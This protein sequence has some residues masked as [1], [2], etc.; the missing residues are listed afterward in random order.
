MTE[1]YIY[2]AVRSPRGK[3]R[4]DGAL[5]EITPI[6]LASQVLAAIRDRNGLSGAEIEDVAFGCVSP[7]GEQGA[8][9]TRTAILCRLSAHDIGH[10]GK[11]FL[12]FG[13]RGIQHRGCQ[14]EVWR[15]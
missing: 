14:G 6:D 2:D 1:A 15:M 7:V 12:R 10:S 4:P 11:P 9:I 5:H 13:P 8:V 3:G